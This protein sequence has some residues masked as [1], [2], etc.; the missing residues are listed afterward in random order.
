[1]H[2]VLADQGQVVALVK[3]QFEVGKELIGHGGVVRDVRLHA[4]AITKVATCALEL[5]L[6]IEAVAPSPLPGPAGNVEYFLY[7]H[8]GTENSLTAADLQAEIEAAIISGPA[9][10]GAK[11]KLRR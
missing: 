1:M 7:M 11:A 5:G 3:P 6:S 10:K 9:G 4:Q 2:R 8:A